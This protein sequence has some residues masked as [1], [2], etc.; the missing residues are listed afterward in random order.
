[1]TYTKHIPNILSLTRVL[2]LIPFLLLLSKNLFVSAF[3]LFLLAAI[4]DGL[5]GY[6]AR[7]LSCQSILG[8]YLD[9][10]SDKIFTLVTFISLAKLKL[11]STA[12][13][14]LIIIRDIL[15]TFGVLSWLSFLGKLKLSPLRTGK[16]NT[17]FQLLFLLV[18][19]YQLAFITQSAPHAEQQF[20]LGAQKVLYVFLISTT[21]ISFF[22]Y[23]YIWLK[24]VLSVWREKKCN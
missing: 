5:D 22:Q 13:V 7:R 2:L 17:T 3:Y 12:L 23:V 4:S 18:I 16:L 6:L 15:I 21:L 10:I 1:M 24:K 14:A 11:I 20:F 9:P 19:L 8:S